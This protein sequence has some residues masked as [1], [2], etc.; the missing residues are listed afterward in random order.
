MQNPKP[1][2]LE[3]Y[4]EILKAL[5]QHKA[6]RLADIQQKTSV[7]DAFLKH[8]IVFLEKQNL[9]E[10]SDLKNVTVY[11]NTERGDRVTNYFTA[12][13]QSALRQEFAYLI[14]ND[15]TCTNTTSPMKN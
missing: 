10:K 7:D 13:P 1:S 12:Q 11:R 4:L 8:A 5:K 9:V 15:A 2:K 14:P 6:S 3:L